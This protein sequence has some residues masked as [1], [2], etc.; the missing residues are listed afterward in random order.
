MQNVIKNVCYFE[1]GLYY[2]FCNKTFKNKKKPYNVHLH[3]RDIY[4]ALRLS[5][6]LKSCENS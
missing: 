2:V 4:G 3:L 5:R 6:Y 1:L